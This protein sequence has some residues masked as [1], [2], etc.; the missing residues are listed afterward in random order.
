MSIFVMLLL[1]GGALFLAYHFTPSTLAFFAGYL[2]LKST[3]AALNRRAGGGVGGGGGGGG[4]PGFRV[5]GKGVLGA[6]ARLAQAKGGEG[7]VEGEG[8]REGEGDGG[9]LETVNVVST[10]NPSAVAAIVDE[11]GPHLTTA[12]SS[13]I[14]W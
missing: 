8:Q 3:E 6:S 14:K 1:A 2:G 4:R 13:E 12:Q 11:G 7:E 5:R 10:R 9:A